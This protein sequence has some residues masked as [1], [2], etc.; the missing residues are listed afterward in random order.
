VAVL[1]SILHGNGLFIH[2]T[3][4]LEALV[5]GMARQWALMVFLGSLLFLPS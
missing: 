2:Y 1:I 5:K 4:L 3:R